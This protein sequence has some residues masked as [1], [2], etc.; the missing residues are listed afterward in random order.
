MKGQMLLSLALLACGT[1]VSCA[2]PT[3]N[4]PPATAT[5]FPRV[6]PPTL[7]PTPNGMIRPGGRL[8][9]MVLTTAPR[10]NFVEFRERSDI[11]NTCDPIVGESGTY[12]RECD[13]PSML[14]LF[15]GYGD[16]APAADALD[17]KWSKTTWQLILDD[18]QVDLSRFGTADV[19]GPAR[20]R[21]WN[22]VL[23]HPSPGEHVLRYVR[24]FEGKSTAVTWRFTVLAPAADR[25]PEGTSP[26]P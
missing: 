11:F 15:I 12:T 6:A 21:L 26:L 10:D 4:S 22:V 17:A 7:V 2:V 1:A 13:V 8:D 3:S 5:P 24:T 9:D 20:M 18:R 14:E 23:T 25:V 16:S 19:N